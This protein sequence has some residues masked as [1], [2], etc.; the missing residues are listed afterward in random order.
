MKRFQE[1]LMKDIGWKLLSIAIAAV[2]WFM[3]INITQPVD[4][5]SYSRPITL[6]NLETLTSQGLTIGNEETLKNTKITIKVKAQRTALDR[7]NQNPEWLQASVDFSGLTAAA[8]GDIITLPID[9]TMQ[10]GLTDCDIVSKNPVAVEAHVETLVSRRLSIHVTS[11]RED[12]RAETSL[13]EAKESIT[14]MQKELE[15]TD[16]IIAKLQR[17]VNE[18]NECLEKNK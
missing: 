6:K 7:L 2:M 5:R 16:D 15:M 4:T 13:Q 10:N 1:L 9:I 3:V 8:S 12:S 18:S 17:Q 14:M 11:H